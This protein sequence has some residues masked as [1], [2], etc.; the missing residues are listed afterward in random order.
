ML[1]VKP[2]EITRSYRQ[3]LKKKCMKII[4]SITNG[5]NDQFAQSKEGRS[6]TRNGGRLRNVLKNELKILRVES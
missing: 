6:R 1:I 2:T 5:G 3:N 4:C